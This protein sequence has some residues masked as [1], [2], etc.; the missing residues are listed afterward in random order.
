MLLWSR[1]DL[2]ALGPRRVASWS[3]ITQKPGIKSPKTISAIR[4]KQTKMDF[5]P[6]WFV[7]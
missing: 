7:R 1:E 6:Q 3:N 4:A 2:R 5:N